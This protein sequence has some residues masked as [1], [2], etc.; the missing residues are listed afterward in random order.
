MG[1]LRNILGGIGEFVENIVTL[2]VLAIPALIKAAIWA[3][4]SF[5]SFANDILK[6]VNGKLKEF[7]NQGATKNITVDTNVMGRYIKEQQALGNYTEISL[8]ELND[9]E[10]GVLNVVMDDNDNII[11]DQ[12]IRSK[13]GLSSEA[14]ARF[15]G[16][17]MMKVKLC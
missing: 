11:D 2:V 13:R 4:E 12:L 1:V 5:I 14:K 17:P 7:L 15:N 3:V 16:K 8:S 9:F 10:N 6:W